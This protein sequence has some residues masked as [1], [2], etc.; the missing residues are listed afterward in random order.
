MIRRGWKGKVTW[1]QGIWTISQK[2]LGWGKFLGSG[3]SPFKHCQPIVCQ[4]CGYLSCLAALPQPGPTLLGRMSAPTGGISLSYLHV[5]APTGGI[6][7]SYLHGLLEVGAGLPA[8]KVPALFP[9]FYSNRVAV[10]GPGEWGRL[11]DF[12]LSKAR[13]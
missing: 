2:D 6:S 13:L 4:T 5:S 12:E 9:S 7:L 10:V 11:L 3:C 8:S 1:Q